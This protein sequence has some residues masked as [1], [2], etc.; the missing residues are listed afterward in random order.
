M[1]NNTFINVCLLFTLCMIVLVFSQ[2]HKKERSQVTLQ[3][4]RLKKMPR[5]WTNTGFCPPAPTNSTAAITD[6]FFSQDVGLNLELISALPNNR[7]GIQTVRI[8]WLMNLIR[9]KYV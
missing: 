6:F 2:V 8:H 7:Y 9:F 1:L 3:I 5:F 4:D